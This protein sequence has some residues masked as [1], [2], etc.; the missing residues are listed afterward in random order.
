MKRS[1][2]LKWHYDEF[3]V[4][5]CDDVLTDL[6]SL[7]KRTELAKLETEGVRFNRLVQNRFSEAPFLVFDMKCARELHEVDKTSGKREV[8][9]LYF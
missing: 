1:K 7:G 8:C 2:R 9:I 4:R 5:V 3:N 6:F